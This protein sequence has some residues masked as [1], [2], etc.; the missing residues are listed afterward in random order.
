MVL[1]G[2]DVDTV[3][4]DVVVDDVFDDVV[5]DDDE[6][7]ECCWCACR[8]NM[9]GTMRNNTSSLRNEKMLSPIAVSFSRSN[10]NNR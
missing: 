6:E 10:Q 1:E 5:D 3:V 4:D 8:V 2:S 9:A 7:A